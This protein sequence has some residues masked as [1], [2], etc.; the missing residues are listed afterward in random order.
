[1]GEEVS[2]LPLCKGDTGAGLR[3]RSESGEPRN[4][5]LGDGEIGLSPGLGD[6]GI[7]CGVR[8]KIGE[9]EAAEP[10]GEPRNGVVTP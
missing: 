5:C 4:K 6:A 3:H 2:I 7:D 10:T 9:L 8:L 1:M